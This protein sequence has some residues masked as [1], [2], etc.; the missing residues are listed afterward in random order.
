LL[1]D[2]ALPLV[3]PEEEGYH[4]TVG[5]VPVSVVAPAN[6]MSDKYRLTIIKG[7]IR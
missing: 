3:S 2:F 5:E 7:E 1:L 4:P 6:I